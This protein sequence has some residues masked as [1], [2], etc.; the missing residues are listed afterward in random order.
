[1]LVRWRNGDHGHIHRNDTLGEEAWD[2]VK[3]DGDVVGPAIVHGFPVGWTY[4]EGVVPEVP[5]HLRG[6]KG[7]IP[8]E[9]N[10]VE[11]NVLQLGP[12]VGQ[13]P[14]QGLGD[15]GV[16]TVVDSVSTLYDGHRLMGGSQFRLVISKPVHGSP[17]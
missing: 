1:V 10:M 11:L 5:C 17:P 3:E 15:R 6:G 2:H 12:P 16:S 7:V 9:E 4:E 8:Q 13:G 14:D